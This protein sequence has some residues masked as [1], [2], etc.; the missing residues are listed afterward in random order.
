MER[1]AEAISAYLEAIA[2]VRSNDTVTFSYGVLWA[3]YVAHDAEMRTQLAAQIE[4]QTVAL[5]TIAAALS[6]KGTSHA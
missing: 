4:R 6:G 2:A 5:E 1:L 3:A